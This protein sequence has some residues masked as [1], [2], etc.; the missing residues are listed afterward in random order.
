MSASVAHTRIMLYL[1]DLVQHR[2]RRPGDDLISAMLHQGGLSLD[3]TLLNCDNVFNAGN[4]TTQ[5][6]VAAMF[7]ALAV[8]PGLLDRL[9]ADPRLVRNAVEELLRWSTPGPHVLRVTTAE[10]MLNDQ[11]IAA[12]TPVVSWLAAANRDGRV[13]AAPD[14]FIP[15]RQP[16]RHLSFGSGIHYCVGAAMARI[17]LK[18]LFEHLAAAARAVELV[19]PPVR[20]RSTKVNGYRRLPVAFTWRSPLRGGSGT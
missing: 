10:V 9:R 1:A 7:H 11:A 3:D 19:E 8:T 17:E 5:H 13:F 18:V 15:D 6:S 20:L 14:E 12:G 4:A 2:R 16:N